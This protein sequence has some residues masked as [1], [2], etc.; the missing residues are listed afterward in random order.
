MDGSAIQIRNDDL[1]NLL[2]PEFVGR[3][4]PNFAAKSFLAAIGAWTNIRALWYFG[5]ADE[6]QNIPD[7]TGQGR[8]IFSNGTS[9]RAQ[10]VPP[11]LGSFD[12]GASAYWSRSDIHGGFD[13]TGLETQVTTTLRGLTIGCWIRLEANAVAG[14]IN[15]WTAGNNSYTLQVAVGP[16]FYGAMSNAGAIAEAEVVSATASTGEYYF[17]CLVF[18]PSTYLRLY[19]GD[20]AGN[21]T[22][23]EDAAGV[24]AS[25]YSGSAPLELGA[26][27][28]ASTLNGDFCAVWIAAALSNPYNVRMI[29]EQTQTAFAGG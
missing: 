10:V 19:V 5:Y 8:T 29:W 4:E 27:N 24:P 9:M 2:R 14:I 3:N 11:G 28:G 16:Q 13:I 21:F 17:L 22:Y 20:T 12:G 25:I 1:V 6:N 26:V 23:T 7:I 18:D 15:K